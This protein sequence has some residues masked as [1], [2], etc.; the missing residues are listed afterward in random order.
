MKKLLV[1]FATGFVSLFSF[2]QKIDKIINPTEVER[3][4]RILSA[5]DMQGRKTFTPG[6]DKAADF[7]AAVSTSYWHALVAQ[8][9]RASDYESEGQEFESLR[10]RHFHFKPNTEDRVAA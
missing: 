4:E 2:A 6:I 9:D 10:A 5:D 8:L 1:T 7:I 3:I